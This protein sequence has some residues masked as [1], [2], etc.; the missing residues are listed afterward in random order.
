MVT[1]NHPSHYIDIDHLSIETYCDLGFPH[2]KK[3]PKW[4]YKIVTHPGNQTWPGSLPC[5][6]TPEGMPCSSQSYSQPLLTSIR[7]YITSNP[8]HQR[9]LSPKSTGPTI[10]L[11]K[12]YENPLIIN[13]NPFIIYIYVHPKNMKIYSPMNHRYYHSHHLPFT[14]QAMSAQV[15]RSGVR[16]APRCRCGCLMVSNMF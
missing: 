5:L 16:G 3:T 2:F 1:P 13:T 14:I 8:C 11:I 10:Y 4:G 15:G 9:A 7:Y 6:M 12:I